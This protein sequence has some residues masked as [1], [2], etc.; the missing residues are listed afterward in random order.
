VVGIGLLGEAASWW[1][2]DLVFA[3]VI[4]VLAFLALGLEIKVSAT[5]RAEWPSLVEYPDQST[6]SDQAPV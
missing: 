4:A 3:A 1:I 5:P 6:S 2:A